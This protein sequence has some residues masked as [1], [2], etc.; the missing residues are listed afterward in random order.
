M[1]KAATILLSL[2]VVLMSTTSMGKLDSNKVQVTLNQ[3]VLE[4]ADGNLIVSW[5]TEKEIN[6]AMF[7]LERSLDGG[8]FETV[9]YVDGAGNSNGLRTYS[10][11]DVAPIGSHLSYKLIDF[12]NNIIII[13][14]IEL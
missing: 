3:F 14:E 2:A 5:A 7:T 8:S 1:K 10:I 9:D 11:L 13:E 6:N 12:G 4:N